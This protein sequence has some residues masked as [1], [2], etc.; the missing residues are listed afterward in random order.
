VQGVNK[1]KSQVHVEMLH[2]SLA[3][4][5]SV[6]RGIQVSMVFHF[7]LVRTVVF[8][9]MYPQPLKSIDL[10]KGVRLVASA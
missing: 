4:G 8:G 5:S 9:S 3:D 10:H 1:I 2:K 7:Y 6:S